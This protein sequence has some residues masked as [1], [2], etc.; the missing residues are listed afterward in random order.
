MYLRRGLQAFF[1]RRRGA[2]STVKNA[3]TLWKL[4]L[5]NF[6]LQ[7]FI[8]RRSRERWVMH[9]CLSWGSML[10]F[11]VTFPLVFGWVHFES[12]ADNAEIY[13]VMV[14]G[15]P[16]EQF[17]VHSVS[18]FLLFN[19][20]NLSAIVLLAGLALSIKL[21]MSD[22]GEFAT[23]SFADDV[24]PLLLLF[25]VCVTG[26]MLTVSSKFLAGSGFQ[27]IGMT[28]AAS[29][30]GLLLYLPFG[31]LFHIIQRPL[32]LGV[33]FYKDAGRAGAAAACVRCG[34]DYASQLH[35]D[36]LKTVLDELGFD[37]RFAT[38]AGD[39]HYQDVC[40]RCRRRLLALNQGKALGR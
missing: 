27:F 3:G 28:H 4:L 20:L 12:T 15:V 6:L 11:A 36:D 7:R 40:P 25:A 13:R 31:K 35:V 23:Q 17:S 33:S 9:A 5:D 1:S 29:V 14:M 2:L 10:A 21:R 32:S 30:I 22:K 19:L 37:F 38:A 39:L 18:G 16:V 26:L 34:E 24:I 8:T